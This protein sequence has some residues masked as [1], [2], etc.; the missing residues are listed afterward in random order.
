MVEEEEEE[1]VGN[2]I[3]SRAPQVERIPVLELIPELVEL[4]FRESELGLV[5]NAG[6][7]KYVVPYVHR[8]LLSPAIGFSQA[9][10]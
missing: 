9:H 6:L 7:C 1:V 10:L 2:E 4:L 5:L 8:E 3:L